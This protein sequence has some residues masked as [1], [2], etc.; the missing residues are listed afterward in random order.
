M[1]PDASNTY[2]SYAEA[3]MVS[4]DYGKAIEY[5]NKSLE[6]NPDNTNATTMLEEIDRRIES[7]ATGR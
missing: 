6:L 5:Y 2:D 1:F 3:C 4:G 7:D